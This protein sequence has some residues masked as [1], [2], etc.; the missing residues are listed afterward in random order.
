M[1][2]E[3]KRKMSASQKKRLSNPE[4]H[5]RYGITLSEDTKQKISDGHK[6]KKIAKEVCEKMSKS[7]TGAKNGRAKKPVYCVEFDEMFWGAKAVED[8]YGIDSTS[9][10]SACSGRQKHAGRHPV[11]N[12]LLTWQYVDK[13]IAIKCLCNILKQIVIKEEKYNECA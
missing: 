3:A 4:N 5:P 6:G 13:P 12:E 9:I 8:K 11:T 1:S 2:D 10:T 7:R